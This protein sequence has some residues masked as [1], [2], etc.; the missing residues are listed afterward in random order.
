MKETRPIPNWA[1]TVLAE[2]TGLTETDGER[3]YGENGQIRMWRFQFVGLAKQA[4]DY[5]DPLEFL[6]GALH[7]W[8]NGYD[9]RPAGVSDDYWAGVRAGANFY[10]YNLDWIDNDL[11]K[12]S[13]PPLSTH[14]YDPKDYLHLP[15]RLRMPR[16]CR[17]D[18]T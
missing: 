13:Q 6:R 15:K 7:G 1:V 14:F 3:M 16:C 9:V 18:W 8:H 12:W 2:I 17:E 11:P 5:S 10:H 4:E